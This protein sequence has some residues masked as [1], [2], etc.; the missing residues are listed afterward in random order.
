VRWRMQAKSAA[1]C[2]NDAMHAVAQTSLSL[3]AR[4]VWG[5]GGPCGLVGAGDAAATMRAWL[6]RGVPC[7][8]LRESLCPRA[9]ST[10]HTRQS[11]E[12]RAQAWPLGRRRRSGRCDSGLQCTTCSCRRPAAG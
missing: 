7:S 8:V 9:Q 11:T 1:D 6:R 4:T 10:E 12:H 5:D 2:C 3:Q